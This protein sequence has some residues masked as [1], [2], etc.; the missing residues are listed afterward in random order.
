MYS[1]AVKCLP[2]NE[3]IWNDYGVSFFRLKQYKKAKE[4]LNKAIVL[5]SKY[6]LAYRNLAVI[7]W[8]GKDDPAGRDMAEKAASLDPS[9]ENLR[10]AAHAYII[11]SGRQTGEEKKKSLRMAAEYYR[12]I[13]NISEAS[14]H[15]LSIIENSL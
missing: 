6:A 14:Q 12:R 11:L 7:A 5:I 9:D 1:Q 2:D 4:A 13:K 10:Y 3:V 15:N 8:Q